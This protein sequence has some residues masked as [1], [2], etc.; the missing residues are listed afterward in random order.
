M[1]LLSL[2]NRCGITSSILSP[3]KLLGVPF[4]GNS[5]LGAA[6]PANAVGGGKTKLMVVVVVGEWLDNLSYSL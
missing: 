5:L 3:L 6:E 1:S 2:V 4:G